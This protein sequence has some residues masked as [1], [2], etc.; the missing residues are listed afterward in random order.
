MLRVILMVFVVMQLSACSTINYV[1]NIEDEEMIKQ[2]ERVVEIGKEGFP[3]LQNDREKENLEK[4]FY[5]DT[6]GGFKTVNSK[7]L[8][9]T[10]S[11][12][13]LHTYIEK[14]IGENGRRISLSSK[15]SEFRGDYVNL[16]KIN[17]IEFK[18]EGYLEISLSAMAKFKTMFARPTFR[19]N[20]IKLQMRP[21]LISVGLN[22][23]NGQPD[24]R[25]L[26][27]TGKFAVSYLDID[28]NGG[29]FDKGIARLLTLSINKDMN[30]PVS[31]KLGELRDRLQVVSAEKQKELDDQVAKSFGQVIAVISKTR[32]SANDVVLS[33]INAGYIKIEKDKLS[34]VGEKS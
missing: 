7:D 33:G 16:T 11:K 3:V 31:P 27:I 13:L 25:V 29:S 18:E 10:L 5:Y 22:G 32:N 2:R 19:V 21:G 8:N 6:D 9:I 26:A 23:Q 15:E 4:A 17:S 1:F 12:K 14:F 28:E 30:D 24:E 20:E 34:V